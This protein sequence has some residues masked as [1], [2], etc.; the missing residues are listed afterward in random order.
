MDRIY[1]NGEE[2]NFHCPD[3]HSVRD[4]ELSTLKDNLTAERD[5]C[6]TKKLESLSAQNHKLNDSVAELSAI[7]DNLTELLQTSNDKLSSI[8]KERDLLNANLAQMTKNLRCLFEPNK[9]CPA[10]WQMFSCSCYFLSGKPGSWDEGRQ[11]CRDKGADLVVIDSPEERMF[12][13]I[14]INSNMWIGLS[15]R[16]VEGTWKWVDGTPLTLK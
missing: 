11:D 8:T 3:N 1:I 14:S 4:A 15:D 9:V 7:K 10:G 6:L 13:S 12:L 16:E 2:A 5:L